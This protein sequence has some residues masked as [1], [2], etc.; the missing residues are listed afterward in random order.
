MSTEM[1]TTESVRDRVD[2]VIAAAHDPEAAHG[3]EDDLLWD[4]MWWFVPTPI[5]NELT[6][7]RD[8][9]FPRWRA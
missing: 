7:M 3:Y 8:A 9:D 2:K 5:A 4:L 1:P 6:R